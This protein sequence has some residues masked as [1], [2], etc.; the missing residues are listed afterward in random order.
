[1][2]RARETGA[3]EVINVRGETEGPL[4]RAA[5]TEYAKLWDRDYPHLAPH[6]VQP[7][8]RKKATLP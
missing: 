1:M 5:A 7:R 8:R 4:T 2:S 3:Y 6:K